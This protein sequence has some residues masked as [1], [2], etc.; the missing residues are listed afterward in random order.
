MD[1]RDGKWK[2]RIKHYGRSIYLGTFK[3]MEE[4]EEYREQVKIDLG[5]HANH[6]RK[7][8]N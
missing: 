2:A 7:N 3:S 6:G 8:G 1:M 5:Y 4:A